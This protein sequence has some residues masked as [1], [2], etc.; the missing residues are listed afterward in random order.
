MDKQETSF[1]HAEIKDYNMHV[2]QLHSLTCIR[3]VKE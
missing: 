2:T 1:Y 3:E